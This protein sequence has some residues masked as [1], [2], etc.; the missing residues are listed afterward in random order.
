MA[1]DIVVILFQ[2]YGV[3]GLVYIMY[4]TIWLVLLACSWRVLLRIQFWIGGVIILGQYI[5]FQ[6]FE[7]TLQ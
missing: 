6:T 4:G 3:M 5:P 1:F 7:L 2:F